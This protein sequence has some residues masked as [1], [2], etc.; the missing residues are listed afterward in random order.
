MSSHQ[1]GNCVEMPDSMAL[2]AEVSTAIIFLK[3]KITFFTL[4][5]KVMRQLNHFTM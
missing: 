3:T 2:M 4:S 5:I 1:F